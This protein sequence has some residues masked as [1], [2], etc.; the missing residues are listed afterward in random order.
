VGL[1]HDAAQAFER[2]L[3]Y[4]ATDE[5]RLLML[6]RLAISLQMCGRWEESKGV[7]YKSRQLQ[8]KTAPNATT[9]DEV[10]LALFETRWRGSL[11]QLVLL[12]DLNACARN[13]DASASHRVACGQ[14][15]LKVATDQNRTDVMKELY[16][17]M[18]P[19][20]EHPTVALETSLEV[21]M[22]YHSICGDMQMAEQAADRLLGTVRD[23]RDPR[24]LSRALCNV[25]FAYRL[26]GRNEEA[27][28]LFLRL[29]DLSLTQGLKAR[30]SFACLGLVRLYLGCGDILQARA[31]MQ[32]LEALTEGDQDFQR[33][34]DRLYFSARIAL[35]E[36]NVEEAAERYSVVAAQS[37]LP[38]INWRAAILAV[39]VR[40]AIQKEASVGILRPMVTELKGAHL[41]NR[42][43]GSQDF[44]THALALGLRYCGESEEGLRLLSEYATTYRRE[45]WALPQPL[46]NLLRD[47]QGSYAI[48]ATPGTEPL[49]V[50]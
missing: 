46:S 20:L 45:R 50:S 9:H 27:E 35:E 18:V 33:T 11:E 22:I 47:L 29:L 16:L 41:Q 49:S 48:S 39:G 17:T 5:Q 38:G 25:G 31:A 26:A 4:C 42:G 23:E 6:S 19:L 14:L 7:L 21:E 40:I 30:V 3:E 15:G 24:I 44:E 43:A 32:K 13:A 10:E 37:Y 36:G 12:D 28:A 1:T 34:T 2:T 8:A